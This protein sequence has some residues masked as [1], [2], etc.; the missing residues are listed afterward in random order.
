MKAVGFRKF[1]GPE[2]LEIVERAE[3]HAGPGQ[4]R[5]VVHAA[6]INS[7]DWRKRQGLME[8]ELPQ[9]L[10]DEAAG[11]VDEVGEG[12]HDVAVGD[13]V[14]GLS[15]DGAAQA[16]LAIL[17]HYAQIPNSLTFAAVAALPT[18]IETATRAL[19][20]LG[21]ADGTTVL[22]NGASGGV[23]S[24]AVQLA[25]I[26]GAR[27]IGIASP[28]NHEYLQSLGATPVTYGA[29]LAER[30][31]QLVPAGVDVAFDVAGSGILPELIELT[32][33]A[34]HVVTISDFV[35]AL[36]HGVTFSG[37]DGGRAIHA[38]AQVGTWIDEGR[39]RLPVE[40]EFTLA[41]LAEAH[42]KSEG[43]H[44]RGKLILI[45]KES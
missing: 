43:G 42:R 26:R 21:V 5:I 34:E 15:A 40:Q 4:I 3:P 30:V 1:G 20:F 6:G 33:T 2:V 28:A 39:F 37:G 44:T 38:I 13:R 12:V 27:V 24:A 11:V 36:M 23:G 8:Q 31:R 19:D 29:G 32:G 35:G 18:A 41:D 25:L 9:S 14:F 16:E 45:V 22:V 17:D 10:G 7:V